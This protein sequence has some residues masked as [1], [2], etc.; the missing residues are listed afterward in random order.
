MASAVQQLL[1]PS[2]MGELFKFLA[3]GRGVMAPLLGFSSGNRA[4]AL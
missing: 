2:E 1:A 3:L 4:H